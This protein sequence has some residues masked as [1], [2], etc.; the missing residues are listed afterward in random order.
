MAF[1]KVTGGKINRGAG[2][3]LEIPCIYQLYG[4]REYINK[5]KEIIDSLKIN[6]LGNSCYLNHTLLVSIYL[7]FFIGPLQNLFPYTANRL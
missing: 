1:A 6:E 2:Y 7:V 4:P 5:M 3:A